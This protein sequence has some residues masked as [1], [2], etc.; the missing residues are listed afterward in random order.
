MLA[1]VPIFFLEQKLVLIAALSMALAAALALLL[2]GQMRLIGLILS[3]T[4]YFSRQLEGRQDEIVQN[5][6]VAFR[7]WHRVLQCAKVDIAI[8][9][10][11]AAYKA[12]RRYLE[13][14]VLVGTVAVYDSKAQAGACLAKLTQ[15]LETFNRCALLLLR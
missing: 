11:L 15:T 2:C 6:D 9:C 1:S 5:L 3:P 4:A 8:L 7:V 12:I 14:L 13:H 10:P